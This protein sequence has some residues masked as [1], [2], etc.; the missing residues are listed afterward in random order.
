MEAKDESFVSSPTSE[1]VNGHAIEE[2]SKNTNDQAISSV[3]TSDQAA[4]VESSETKLVTELPIQ[5]PEKVESKVVNGKN[6]NLAS[7]VKDTDNTQVQEPRVSTSE[8]KDSLVESSQIEP[9]ATNESETAPAIQLHT[10][11]ANMESETSVS[12]QPVTSEMDT[13]EKVDQRPNEE[14]LVETTQEIKETY[15][16][17]SLA[18]NVA[19]NDNLTRI[20]NEPIITVETQPDIAKMDSTNDQTHESST[21]L[22]PIKL[23]EDL[24]V[25]TSESHYEDVDGMEL[26]PEKDTIKEPS[27]SEVKRDLFANIRYYLI[28]ST[29]EDEVKKLKFS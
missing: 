6:D 18:T 27:V 23:K 7:E 25:N 9:A 26:T 5:E 24:S 8:I 19:S 13:T 15:E 12:I 4:V 10:S 29:N 21:Y 28:N 20:D 16:M 17:T 22:S 2:A 1:P 3:T 14:P 11:P